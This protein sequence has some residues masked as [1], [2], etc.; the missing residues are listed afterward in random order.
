M[1]NKQGDQKLDHPHPQGLSFCGQGWTVILH[2]ANL[3][4]KEVCASDWLKPISMLLTQI[5]FGSLF[6]YVLYSRSGFMLQEVY[7]QFRLNYHRGALNNNVGNF[8]VSHFYP[9][10]NS[11]GWGKNGS[12]LFSPQVCLVFTPNHG[13]KTGHL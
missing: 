7:L 6:F 5:H 9:I 13:V 11:A 8:M 2:K 10:G 12:V 1:P 3:E 4:H